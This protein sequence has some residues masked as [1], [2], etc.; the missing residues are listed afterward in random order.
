VAFGEGREEEEREGP[1]GAVVV[2][3]G[4]LHGMRRSENAEM[5]ERAWARKSG[6]SKAPGL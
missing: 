6:E 5:P 3:N 2:P 4:S 1:V